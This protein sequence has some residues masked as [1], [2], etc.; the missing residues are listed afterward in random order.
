MSTRS[1][2]ISAPRNIF[3]IG[4][5]GGIGRRLTI[6]LAAQGHRVTGMH[7]AGGQ[8]TVIRDAGGTPVNGDLIGDWC[9]PCPI[10]FPAMTPS[11]SAPAPTELART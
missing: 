10:A 7:R 8:D 2:G 1:Q 4:A 6:L 5:A 9:K 11:C 3:L